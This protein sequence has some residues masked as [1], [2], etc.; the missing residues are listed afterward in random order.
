MS[1]VAANPHRIRAFETGSQTLYDDLYRLRSDLATEMRHFRERCTEFGDAPLGEYEDLDA[2][3]LQFI[4]DVENLGAGT[5][6]VADLIEL[7]DQG[8]Y[9]AQEAL[10]DGGVIDHNMGNWQNHAPFGWLGSDREMLA[11]VLSEEE[12]AT[13]EQLLAQTDILY[14]A[15]VL[16]DADLEPLTQHLLTLVRDIEDGQVADPNAPIAAAGMITIGSL[17]LPVP[18]EV[19]TVP[20][21][22]TIAG[23]IAVVILGL[24]YLNRPDTQ[25]A[26]QSIMTE[27]QRLV[28][29]PLHAEGAGRFTDEEIAAALERQRQAWEN[30]QADRNATPIGPYA[31][32][33]EPTVSELEAWAR[34]Q[35]WT[36]KEGTG[37]IV[38]V[39]QEGIRRLE[40]KQEPARHVT[41]IDSAYPRAMY[42][43][44]YGKYRNLYTGEPTTRRDPDNHRPIT[45]TGQ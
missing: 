7:A 11:S 43:D 12:M 21:T 9:L 41:G 26:T 27:L 23:S 39:D 30:A 10:E 2:Q 36:E 8:V 18:D 29:G 34:E 32:S 13:L 33:P 42:R 28:Q 24:N 25:F 17:A 37:P 4:I 35:G 20:V 3:L 14:R 31:D 5:K 16:T 6:L 38:Y 45:V 40:I 44:E 22:W 15:G 1:I 19:V